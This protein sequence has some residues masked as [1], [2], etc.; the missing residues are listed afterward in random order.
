MATAFH[1]SLR[2][3]HAALTKYWEEIFG[4]DCMSVK[5]HVSTSMVVFQSHGIFSVR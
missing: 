2:E 3:I 1:G 5:S 4:A